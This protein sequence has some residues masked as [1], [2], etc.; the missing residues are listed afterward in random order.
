M[1]ICDDASVKFTD[2]RWD[3]QCDINTN[4]QFGIRNSRLLKV[5]CE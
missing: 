4:E 2:P 1:L 5:R 3:I